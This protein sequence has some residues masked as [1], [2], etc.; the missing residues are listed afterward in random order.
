MKSATLKG[1]TRRR[2]SWKWVPPSGWPT[3]PQD[4]TP[5][6]TWEPPGDWP[7]PSPHHQWWRPTRSG[8]IRVIGLVVGIPLLTNAILVLLVTL[9]TL[10]GGSVDPTDPNEL[11]QRNVGQRLCCDFLHRVLEA[12]LPH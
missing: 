5:S 4:W 7:R 9:A 11:L 2:P 3:P 8:R 10:Q 6:A 1:L 12:S